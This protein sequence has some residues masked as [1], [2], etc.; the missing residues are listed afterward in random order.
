MKDEKPLIDR[1][2]C[3]RYTVPVTDL[4]RR[5]LAEILPLVRKRL[6]QEPPATATDPK[7][8][9]SRSQDD[10]SFALRERENGACQFV[11]YDEGRTA[12]AIHKTCLEE[13]LDPWVYKPLG[14]SLWPLAHPR[15]RGRGRRGAAAA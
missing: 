12:C 7:S 13:G 15:L 10:F 11:V 9:P 2:C 1:S 8:R 5:P 6:R 3:S 4:D 14:C